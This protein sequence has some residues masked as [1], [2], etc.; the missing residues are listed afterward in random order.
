MGDVASHGRGFFTDSMKSGE[1]SLTKGLEVH[2]R[3]TVGDAA[4]FGDDRGGAVAGLVFKL[5]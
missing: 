2:G 5:E 1:R 4:H 3:G